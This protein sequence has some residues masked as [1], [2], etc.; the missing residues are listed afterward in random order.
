MGWMVIGAAFAT[1]CG[2]SAY[3]SHRWGRGANSGMSVNM[4]T[5]AH[6]RSPKTWI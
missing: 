1:L 4:E 6:L 2:L 3:L 5:E